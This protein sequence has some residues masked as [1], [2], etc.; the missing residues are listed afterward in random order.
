MTKL[1]YSTFFLIIF[2]TFYFL[3]SVFAANAQSLSLTSAKTS[4]NVGDSF[5]VS[6]LIDTGGKII[7]AVEGAIIIPPDKFQILDTRYGS[8]IISLW[9]ARP[10]INNGEGTISFAGGVPGGFGGSNGPILSFS[11]KAKKS[12]SGK[13]SL[14]DVKVLLNDGHGTELKNI[15]LAG[16]FLTIKE[17]APKPSKE[18]VPTAPKEEEKPVEVYLPPAD[19]VSA[20]KFYSLG[21]SE[22]RGGG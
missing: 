7:N 4:Y 16:L 21:E 13:V 22:F 8:S 14:Q 18:P 9:V 12:G 2:S 1:K 11:L 6:L 15:A 10:T 19:T 20:G 17:A 5:Q 3:L